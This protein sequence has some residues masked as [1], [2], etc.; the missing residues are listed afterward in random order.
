MSATTL[1]ITGAGA[2][3]DWLTPRERSKYPTT[4]SMPGAM[5][6]QLRS[7]PPLTRDLV[8]GLSEQAGGCSALLELIST[9][10]LR[11][12]D[13]F[14]FEAT[15]RHIVD[16]TQDE[17]M[18]EL[19]I[20]RGSIQQRM[21]L[22]DAIGENRDTLYTTLFSSIRGS[23]R[24]KSENRSISVINLNYDRLAEYAMTN[25]SGLHNIN[26]FVGNEGGIN[27]YHPHGN[28]GWSM[29]ETVGRHEVDIL[30]RDSYPG[31]WIDHGK[32]RGYGSACLALP[33]SGDDSGKT[34]WPTK[35]KES[36]KQQLPLV[37]EII[38]IGWRG[39]DSHIVDL[40]AT[41]IGSVKAIH[42][43]GNSSNGVEQAATNIQQFDK[44]GANI[45]KYNSGFRGYLTDS[46]S[47]FWR[48]HPLA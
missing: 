28:C 24:Y 44:I 48:L 45:V 21:A 5:I 34:A 40:V 13:Y 19:K 35:H 6:L 9:H 4:D 15:L 18:A 3:V 11:D 37:D 16:S 12:P 29:S 14:D 8:D 10:Q 22:A 47:P 32:A 46:D 23:K 38:V 39:Y 36:L 20:L 27:L 43:V 30:E 31:M 2:S 25:R 41:G 26:R 7:S 42:V 1:I 33:M 17:F